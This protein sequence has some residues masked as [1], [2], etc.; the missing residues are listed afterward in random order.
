[1]SATNSQFIALLRS[2]L[3]GTPLEPS[4]FSGSTD[5]E[6]ILSLAGRQ[7]VTG[8]ISDAIATLPAELHPPATL[9]RKL[10]FT[11]VRIEQSH[12][13]LNQQLAK[14]VPLLQAEGVNPILLKGQGVA[15]N[16]PNPLHRQCGDI[17]LYVGKS[18]YDK[19]CKAMQDQDIIVDESS[20]SLRHFHF[21]WSGV[22]IE[23]HR[24]AEILY[25]PIQ[26]R[27]F[28]RWTKQQLF[29]SKLRSWNINGAAVQLPPPNF[30]ALY[31]FCHAYRH[32]IEEGIGFRQLCDWTLYLHTF[33][34]EIDRAALKKALK[35]FG[36]LRAWKIFGCIA[37]DVLG[38]D[39]N[40]FPFYSEKH[41]KLAEKA[42][43]EVLQMGN[44]G[45]YNPKRQNRPDS[46][47]SGKLY[48]FAYNQ[49]RIWRL[50]PLSPANIS[51][52]YAYFVIN[53]TSRVIKD[54]LRIR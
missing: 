39:K 38:L 47:Y 54:T 23:L 32:F 16:Y 42:L 25:N 28:Q 21:S 2:G 8:V 24:I 51:T 30:D 19:A 31:I 52:Y 13:L 37:V 40:E 4:L 29:D 9:K 27:R 18:A 11:V 14:V 6:A 26:S 50:F 46:Y 43:K 41:S 17:D 22:D 48:K 7:T 33:C 34:S 36:L 5:W 53:G 10:L 35:S 44:F 49:Q 45:R 1:M 3:W 12:E 15:Q 20:D